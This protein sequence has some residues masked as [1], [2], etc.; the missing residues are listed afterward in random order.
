MMTTVFPDMEQTVGRPALHVLQE[1]PAIP[2]SLDDSQM[3]A[4]RLAVVPA[5][6]LSLLSLMLV[7]DSLSLFLSLPRAQTKEVAL[8]HGPPGTGKTF[9][10]LK[11]MRCLLT[12]TDTRR[13]GPILV[14]CYTNH[15][16]DQ[17]RG[18]DLTLTGADGGG[19]SW[20]GCTR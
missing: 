7:A 17:V 9:V 2:S 8:I 6:S 1:W 11:T 16:L 3:R 19:S 18:F 4:L 5:P 15:A 12:N 10:G 14:V 20:R 13:R